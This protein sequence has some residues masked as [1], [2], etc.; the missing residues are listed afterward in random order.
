V[1]HVGHLVAGLESFV[2]HYGVFAVFLL[3]TIEA[4]GAPVPGETLLIFAAVLAGRGEMSLPGLLTFASAGAVLGDNIG[5]AIGRTLGR[6]TILHYGEKIGLTN[7]R[8]ATVESIFQRYGSATVLCA[9]FFNILRQLNGIVAGILGISWRRFLLFNALGSVLWV[10]VWVLA[11][12]YFTEHLGILT[13]TTLADSLT[14]CESI[15]GIAGIGA[16]VV[17]RRVR[18]WR[19]ERRAELVEGAVR[20]FFFSRLAAA[21]RRCWRKA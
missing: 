3:V 1:E 8:F 17:A 19:G 14:R 16:A 2:H 9:R 6:G 11:A 18:G 4:L 20:R 21:R 15:V 5:Y 12:T 13:S 7:A 10:T